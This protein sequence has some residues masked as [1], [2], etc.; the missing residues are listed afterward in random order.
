MYAS[1]SSSDFT[2]GRR[3]ESGYSRESLNLQAREPG[4]DHVDPV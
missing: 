2:P 1:S 4:A 3:N